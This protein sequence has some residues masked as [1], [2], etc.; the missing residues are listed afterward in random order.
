MKKTLFML[1]LIAPCWAQAQTLSASVVS[2]G[3]NFLLAA[4]ASL[5]VSLGQPLA[6]ELSTSTVK[7]FQGFQVGASANL[8]TGLADEENSLSIFPNP[9]TQQLFI[10]AGEPMSDYTFEL[11][12]AQGRMVAVGQERTDHTATLGME[13]LTP[14]FYILRVQHRKGRVRNILI[15]RSN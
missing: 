12:D 14:A 13:A 8:V 5:S 2:S 3:G 15:I 7:L 6:G 11:I 1:I 4:N 10:H 9:V